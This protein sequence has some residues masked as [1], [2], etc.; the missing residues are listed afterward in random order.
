MPWLKV[1]KRMK[2]TSVTCGICVESFSNIFSVC[3][4]VGRESHDST[5]L[6]DVFFFAFWND[7]T[8]RS[9]LVFEVGFECFRFGTSDSCEVRCTVIFAGTTTIFPPV[10]KALIKAL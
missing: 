7:L 8:P 5:W 9:L 10:N 1:T 2:K 6:V 3:S 4:S